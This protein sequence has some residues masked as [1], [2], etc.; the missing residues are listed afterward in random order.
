M[1]KQNANKPKTRS[2]LKVLAVLLASLQVCLPM[3]AGADLL[4]A[5]T[6]SRGQ[7][8]DMRIFFHGLPGQS[9]ALQATSNFASNNWTTLAVAVVQTNGL[10]T[11]ID[12]VQT[13]AGQ[14]FYR[15]ALSNNV[16]LSL[17]IT[18]NEDELFSIPLE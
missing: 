6:I 9:A 3:C 11:F 15:V 12:V 5:V 1:K 14:R 17:H 16:T 2:D 4:S 13:N 7:A 18:G 10:A 8:G